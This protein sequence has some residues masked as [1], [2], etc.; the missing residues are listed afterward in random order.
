MNPDLAAFYRKLLAA[1][2]NISSLD[3]VTAGR[4]E[5]GSWFASPTIADHAAAL[6]FAR[7]ARQAVADLHAENVANARKITED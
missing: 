3:A 1:Q 7:E 4:A 2:P 5:F 6:R